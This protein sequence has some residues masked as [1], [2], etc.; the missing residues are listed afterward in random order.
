MGLLCSDNITVCAILHW[1]TSSV[2]VHHNYDVLTSS[3]LVQVLLR[4]VSGFTFP[5]YFSFPCYYPSAVS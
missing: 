1:P 2:L 4:T 3:P 5:V